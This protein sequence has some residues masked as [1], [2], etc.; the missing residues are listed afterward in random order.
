MSPKKRFCNNL[1]FLSGIDAEW[2][3]NYFCKPKLKVG[4]EWVSIA[5]YHMV[6]HFIIWCCIVSYGIALYLMVVL[7]LYHIIC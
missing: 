2:M 3:I 1:C 4:T 7:W 6:L 5:L